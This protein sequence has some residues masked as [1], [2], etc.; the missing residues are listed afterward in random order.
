MDLFSHFNMELVYK[1][2]YSSEA[3]NL[4]LSDS[5]FITFINENMHFNG[6]EELLIGFSKMI[7]SPGWKFSVALVSFDR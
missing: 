1:I 3:N 6:R 4:S 7:F 2:M 5:N